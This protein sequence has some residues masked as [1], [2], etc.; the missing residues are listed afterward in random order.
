M[1]RKS[2]KIVDPLP[3]SFFSGKSVLA[4]NRL[5]KLNGIA[6]R[7]TFSCFVFI[8]FLVVMSSCKDEHLLAPEVAEPANSYLMIS[9]QPTVLDENLEVRTV[10]NGL[11]TPI[12][13]AFLNANDIFVLEKDTAANC[14][15]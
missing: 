1:S 11:S 6:T 13:M 9:D 2:Q 14:G 10:V 15:G 12:S 7:I 4:F 8:S 3:G 5:P